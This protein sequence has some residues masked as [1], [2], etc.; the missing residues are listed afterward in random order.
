MGDSWECLGKQVN[1][2]ERQEKQWTAANLH[3][4]PV[5]T[6]THR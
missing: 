4:A 3:L 6:T 2:L 1:T 5:T